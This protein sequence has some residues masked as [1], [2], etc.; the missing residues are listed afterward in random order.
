MVALR[1]GV[2]VVVRVSTHVPLACASL[3]RTTESR[4]QTDPRAPHPLSAGPPYQDP[5]LC[6]AS[7]VGDVGLRF[8]EE[9]DKLTD[10]SK[11]K[12]RHRPRDGLLLL[13][14]VANWGGFELVR[15]RDVSEVAHEPRQGPEK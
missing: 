8:S 9:K 4:L 13:R 2:G 5:R 12:R 10:T 11:Y 14:R 7:C 1:L 3:L 15:D 6:V